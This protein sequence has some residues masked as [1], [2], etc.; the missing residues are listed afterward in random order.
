MSNPRADLSET[1]GNMS[2][3]ELLEC[4]SAGH[5]TEVAIEV[6]RAEFSRRAIVPPEVAKPESAD[7]ATDA[8]DSVTFVTVARSLIPWELDIL[9]ARLEADGIVSFVIDADINRMNS[10]WS[11]AVGGA[12][13]LVPQQR[14]AE[15]KQIIGHVK[16]G[17]FALGEGDDVD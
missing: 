8:Q 13:L 4:W 9:R 3:E 15:A 5:L 10:L 7:D 12:R 11:I 17:Q 2:D 6:A 16:S 1:Y 14:A